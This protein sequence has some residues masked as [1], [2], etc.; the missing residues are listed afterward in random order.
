[1][2]REAARQAAC[3]NNLRQI[4]QGLHVHAQQ[5]KEKFCSGAFDWVSDGEI[6]ESSWVGDLVK[7]GSPVGKMLCPSNAARGSATYNDLLSAPSSTAGTAYACGVDMLGRPRSMAPDSSYI[8]NPGR[9]ITDINDPSEVPPQPASGSGLG[10]GYSESRRLFIEEKV[11]LEFFNTNYTASWWLARGGLRLQADG[12]IYTGGSCGGITTRFSTNGPLSR[13]QVDTSST[14]ASIVPLLGDGAVAGTLSHDV[15]DMPSGTPLVCSVTGGPVSISDPSAI[16]SFPGG[17][18]KA[19]WWGVWMNQTLQDYRQ[20][21]VPH[22]RTCNVLFADGSVRSFSDQNNDGL[23]N[24]GFNTVGGFAD[25][26]QEIGAD[27]VYSLY[28]LDAKRL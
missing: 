21:A 20:F 6:T 15:G 23:L 12:N 8:Y 4:G 14:P 22:R 25:N 10:S 11:Y 9:W 1:V 17:T 3:S 16:P 19:V 13:P 5:H 28:S 24:N 7:Q 26:A 27:E 2:A 18:T